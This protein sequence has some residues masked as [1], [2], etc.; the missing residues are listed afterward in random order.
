MAM[1]HLMTEI[2]DSYWRRFIGGISDLRFERYLTMQLL[3]IFYV[4]LLLGAV[5]VFAA[6]TALCFWFSGWLGMA[7]L[8]VSP[9]LWLMF[10]A[11]V[12]AALEYLVMAYRIMLTVQK[13]DSIPATVMQLTG[14]VE[15]LQSR[16]GGITSNVQD[17]H[18]G[19]TDIRDQV[20]HVRTQVD[21]VTT[22][23]DMA[24]PLLQPLGLAQKLLRGRR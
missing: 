13:M 12:R 10:A 14:E 2:P 11:L 21:H 7:A 15:S 9:V 20:Q 17:I 16:L 18:A 23:V 5:F 3:P 22:T 24:R 6:M 1:A 19:F 8:L 4:L